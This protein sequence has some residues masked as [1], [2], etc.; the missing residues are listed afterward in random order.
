MK[1]I[2]S[3]LFLAIFLFSFTKVFAADYVI[4]SQ[5]STGMYY[6]VF[7]DEEIKASAN[8]RGLIYCLEHAS[9]KDIFMFHINSTGGDLFACLEICNAIKNSKA[10]TI[11]NLY[12]GF[13]AAAYITISCKKIIVNDHAIMMIHSHSQ[14]VYGD[15]TDLQ[16]SIS[17]YKEL[18]IMLLDVMFKNFLTKEE[19]RNIQS[20]TSLWLHE[21]Q[22]KLK[23]KSVGKY[24]E[25]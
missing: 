19:L 4:Q 18:D 20:G 24:L 23:L 8:Y 17:F 10:V 22:I 6:D 2:K 15:V 13:S 1:F 12:R 16:R 25:R 5:T 11:A 3:I 21:D 9:A 7:I 14:G